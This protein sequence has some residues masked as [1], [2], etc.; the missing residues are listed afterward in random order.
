ML[1]LTNDYSMNGTALNVLMSGEL[2][3]LGKLELDA[4]GFFKGTLSECNSADIESGVLY[5][6]IKYKIAGH[7]KKE[8]VLTN[9]IFVAADSEH[10]YSKPSKV[11]SLFKVNRDKRD[12]FEFFDKFDL[13][14]DAFEGTYIGS[15]VK[16]VGM[17]LNLR[18]FRDYEK[19]SVLKSPPGLGGY[20]T[21]E[22]KLNRT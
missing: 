10:D 21:L 16:Y 11:F 7:I 4:A 2:S 19:F 20:A 6:P 13:N 8:G 5:E 14:S 18:M 3:H 22:L 1:K 12:T 15:C 17:G 9:I